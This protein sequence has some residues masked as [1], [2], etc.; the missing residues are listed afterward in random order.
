[1]NEKILREL[2]NNAQRH[3]NLPSF[4]QF[5]QDMQDVEKL[6]SFRQNMSRHYN[7]PDLETLKRDIGF[8]E[9]VICSI[10]RCCKI[11]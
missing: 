8:G 11:Y 5:V 3:Y 1:M 4:E 9:A 2:Y 6:E 7:I 10:T